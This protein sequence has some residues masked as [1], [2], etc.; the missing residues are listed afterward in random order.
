MKMRLTGN[1]KEV[2]VCMFVCLQAPLN[3]HAL[4]IDYCLAIYIAVLAVHSL[5]RV[6]RNTASDASDS[7][8]A[9]DPNNAYISRNALANRRTMVDRS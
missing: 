1:V 5:M 7:S 9:S 4:Q 6:R 2:S 3:Q 8:D